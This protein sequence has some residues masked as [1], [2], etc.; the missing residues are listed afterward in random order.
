[1]VT[2][3]GQEAVNAMFT[4][5]PSPPSLSLFVT[6]CPETNGYDYVNAM[7]TEIEA[8][9]VNSLLSV[10]KVRGGGREGGQTDSFSSSLPATLLF[11]LPVC[12][13]LVRPP[14]CPS[15]SSSSLSTVFFLHCLLPPYPQGHDQRQTLLRTVNI[16]HTLLAKSVSGCL[17]AI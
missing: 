14:L 13:S 9:V 12:L 10:Q 2:Q 17:R 3:H 16:D 6:V 4:G 15:P 11:T 5:T 1:M 7:Y 8:L